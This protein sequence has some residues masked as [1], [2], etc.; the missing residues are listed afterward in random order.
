VLEKVAVAFFAVYR[1]SHG[2]QKREL[3]CYGHLAVSRSIV[4]DLLMNKIASPAS[5]Q[6][7]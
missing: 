7:L 3:T 4:H 2:S 1:S 5:N 6:G